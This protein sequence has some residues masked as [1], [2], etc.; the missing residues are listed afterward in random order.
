[1]PPRWAV[2]PASLRPPLDDVAEQRAHRMAER[3]VRDA[4]GLEEGLGPRKRAVDELVDDD[5]VAGRVGSRIEPQAEN[6]NRSVT[7]ARFS[8]SMLA[9]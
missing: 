8:A 9:R 3:H 1:M 5:E 7:P 4:A 6:E 2:T